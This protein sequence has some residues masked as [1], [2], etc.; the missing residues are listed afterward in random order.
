ML[1]A[2]KKEIGKISTKQSASKI[3]RTES[4]IEATNE[5]LKRAKKRLESAQR[6]LDAATADAEMASNL[7][8]QPESKYNQVTS[9]Q[10]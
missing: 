4:Q 9:I 10:T 7:L 8:N 5:K 6:R 2:Q 3:L 1:S